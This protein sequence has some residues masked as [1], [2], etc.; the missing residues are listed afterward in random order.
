MLAL[1]D[2][3]DEID[4]VG[5]FDDIDEILGEGKDYDFAAI[6]RGKSKK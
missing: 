2:L 6:V 1:L 3:D 5:D 4:E